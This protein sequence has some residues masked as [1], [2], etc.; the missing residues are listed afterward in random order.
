MELS[1]I[2]NEYF[3]MKLHC[4]THLSIEIQTLTVDYEFQPLGD[5]NKAT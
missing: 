3:G 5:F 4:Y 2:I 1:Q